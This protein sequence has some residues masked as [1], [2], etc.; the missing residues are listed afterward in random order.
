MAAKKGLARYRSKKNPSSPIGAVMSMVPSMGGLKTQL[1][2]FVG[3]AA[4][5][6]IATR[7]VNRMARTSLA[8][9]FPRVGRHSGPLASLFALALIYVTAKKW[10]KIQRYQTPIVAGATIAAVQAIIE[11]Y[12]PKLSW[13]FDANPAPRPVILTR[14]APQGED[15]YDD[16][17]VQIPAHDEDSNPVGDDEPG[18]EPVNDEPDDDGNFKSMFD[19]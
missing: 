4:G 6:Y 5:G 15:V 10:S 7:V 13:L 14:A 17:V 16:D 19:A 1:A 18:D 9:R 12:L 2:T 3:P 8:Q 11:T